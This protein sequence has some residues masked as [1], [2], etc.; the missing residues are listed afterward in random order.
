MSTECHRHQHL[1]VM[2]RKVW[3]KLTVLWINVKVNET[4]SG[5]VV[6]ITI[7]WSWIELWYHVPVITI[8]NIPDEI[9]C[10]RVRPRKIREKKLKGDTPWPSTFS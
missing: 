9:L 2:N 5:W 4:S 10:Q 6:N 7:M 8:I 3:V 1:S